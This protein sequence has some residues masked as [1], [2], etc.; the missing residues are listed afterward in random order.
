[1]RIKLNFKLLENFIKEIILD[2][3][4]KK[5]KRPGKKEYYKGTKDSNKSMAYEINKCSPKGKPKGWKAPKSC[6]DYWD[7]DKKYDKSKG[8]K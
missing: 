8:K 2:E 1:M 7:A 5:K 3:A 6:Y 4:K